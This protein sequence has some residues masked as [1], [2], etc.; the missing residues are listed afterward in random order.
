M[1]DAS[2]YGLT[3]YVG[4]HIIITYS[5]DKVV[6]PVTNPS[7]VP[8]GPDSHTQLQVESGKLEGLGC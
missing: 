7:C 6:R 5:L 2:P 1:T 3:P 8:N 4:P